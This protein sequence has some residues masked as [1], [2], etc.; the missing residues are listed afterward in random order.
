MG[1]VWTE[2]HRGQLGAVAGTEWSLARVI[3]A[4]DAGQCALLGP[5]YLATRRSRTFTMATALRLATTTEEIR[6]S[7]QRYNDE[8]KTWTYARQLARATVYWVCDEKTGAF[9]P[10]KFAAFAGITAA[11]YDDARKHDATGAYFDGGATRR[12]IERVVGET[13]QGSEGMAERLV[14]WGDGV[15]GEGVFAGI[16]RGRWRFVVIR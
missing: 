10:S 16:E 14:R 1:S 15:F 4:G 12:A 13:Y 6:A 11:G 8:A 5:N 2:E 9:G 7:V 3:R